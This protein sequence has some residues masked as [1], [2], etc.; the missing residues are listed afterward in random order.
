[1]AGISKALTSPQTA[2]LSRTRPHGPR[3]LALN[4]KTNQ[5]FKNN[6]KER[7]KIINNEED[8]AVYKNTSHDLE[9]LSYSFSG[10]G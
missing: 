10:S 5:L 8:N 9:Q 6:R 1:M 2:V 7:E 4:R 3:S